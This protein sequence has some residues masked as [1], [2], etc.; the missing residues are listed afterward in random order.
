LLKA[1]NEYAKENKLLDKKIGEL[2]LGDV[3]S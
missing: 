1:L 2:Q 3:T